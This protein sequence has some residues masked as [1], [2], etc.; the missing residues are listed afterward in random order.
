MPIQAKWTNYDK[1]T[2]SGIKNN[3]GIYEICNKKGEIIYIGEGHLRDRLQDHTR[4]GS[5]FIP[6]ATGFRTIVTKSKKVAKQREKSE[7]FKYAAKN[8]GK[9]PRFNKKIG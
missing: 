9:L 4:H 5:D 3:Y 8:N 7:L 1:A 6:G 2:I